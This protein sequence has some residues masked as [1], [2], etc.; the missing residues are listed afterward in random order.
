MQYPVSQHRHPIADGQRLLRVVGH[1]QA[2]GANAAEH[3]GQLAAQPQPHL[4]IQVGE[5]FIQQQHLGLWRQ[6]PG[7]RQP[8]PLAAR[9]LVR[10][11]AL[12][13]L[14][15]QQFHQ[16]AHPAQVLAAPQTKAGVLPGIQVW[17]Q[18]VVLKHH[19]HP[20]PFRRQPVLGPGH[21]A[22]LYPNRPP[23]R[24]LKARHQS[25]QGG[26]TAT[27]WPQQAHQL[28]PLQR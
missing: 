9:K 12:Q 26:L 3:P 21:L 7:Q 5:G 4:H 1:D 2:T 25:Q 11:A 24:S 17:K 18:C 16:P 27:R 6:S 23:R 15:P 20:P 28:A 8:L 19:A 13:A 14:Q 22:A 10:I